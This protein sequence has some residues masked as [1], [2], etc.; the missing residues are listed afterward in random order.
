MVRFGI[1]LIA[2]FTLTGSFAQ[3]SGYIV[4]SLA[5]T[6]KT[7][8]K[9]HHMW[10]FK[11]KN[12]NPRPYNN[13]VWTGIETGI[14]GLMTPGFNPQPQGVYSFM[15]LDYDRS[16]KFAWNVAEI[17]LPMN[18]KKTVNLLTGVG[19]EWNNYS[20][21]H[22]IALRELNTDFVDLMPG[23][24]LLVNAPDTNV[25]YKR[26]RLQTSWF[27]IPLMV[28]FRTVRKSVRK[29]QFNFTFGVL[30]SVRMGANQR[31]VFLEGGTR[32][33]D[34]RRDDF[35]LNRFRAKAMLRMRFAHVSLFGAYTFTPMFRNGVQLMYPWSAGVAIHPY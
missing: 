27:S 3:Q 15:E 20:F 26:S 13:L 5:D 30:G 25:I 1:S 6:A 18:K 28:N 24:A 29:P 22:K 14:N 34:I 17:K 33:T 35:N 16:W 4:D 23:A 2:L 10:F 9:N 31:E 32:T 21:K 7:C 12:R 11:N 19:F 8:L